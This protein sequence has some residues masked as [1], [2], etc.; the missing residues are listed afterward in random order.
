MKKNK[1]E[2][3][4][5]AYLKQ[6]EQKE[7]L[8]FITCGSVDDGKSTLIGRLLHDSKVIYEDQLASVKRESKKIGTTG[9]EPDLALLVD[10]L[11]AER[12]QGITI[13]VAYRYFSTNKR[14]FI[15]A[16]TPGHEQYTRNMSTGA[17]TANLA[18]ILIDARNGVLTQ[19]KRHSYIVNLLGIKHI[20]V[21]I[22][23]MDLVNYKKVVFDNIRSD[24]LTF[25]KNLDVT[26]INFIP[27]SALKGD[28]V[29]HKSEKMT[30]Y[31][32]KSLMELLDTIE[33]SSDIDLKN[34]RFPVQYVNRP[35][36]DFRG[37]SGTITSGIVRVGDEV[38]ILPSRK[39]SH[40][41]SI[42]TYKQE[43][44]EAFAPMAV[45]LTLNDEIDI[46]R[47]DLIVHPDNTPEVS[48][49]FDVMVVWMSEEPLK[50]GQVYD[51][52]TIAAMRSGYI[53]K[54]HY[55][56]D[57][58]TLEHRDSDVL[59]LNEIAF[60]RLYVTE[61]VPFDNYKFLPATGSFI[62]IDRLTNNTIGAGMIVGKATAGKTPHNSEKINYSE[63]ELEL[64]QLIVKYFPHWG[65]KDLSKK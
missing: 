30:W 7:L 28:N 5:V 43:L 32:G 15:I 3:D 10:G 6:H 12:E 11:Q 41:K 58:N 29:V 21:A 14:K 17:S 39:K 62:F 53:D 38:L 64:N 1:Q 22:N 4:I 59:N 24:Y 13:D 54:I 37:Y 52:K 47:G 57:I 42:I 51:I 23:K 8:R 20:I 61:S 60:C 35:N 46:S 9:D 65:A 45:T 16:D 34:F 31:K 55:T 18:I 56:V 48:D 27:L 19:T 49:A 50:I 40:I 26:D 33:I 25:A 63:F 2:I 44:K 36:A